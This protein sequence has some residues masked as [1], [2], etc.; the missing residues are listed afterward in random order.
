VYFAFIRITQLLQAQIRSAGS[1]VLPGPIFH[2][3]GQNT[4]GAAIRRPHS[5]FKNFSCG[6][7]ASLAIAVLFAKSEPFDAV[8]RQEGMGK[9]TPFLNNNP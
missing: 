8:D 6:L 7:C 9:T 1:L 3:S 2:K 5:V 4:N